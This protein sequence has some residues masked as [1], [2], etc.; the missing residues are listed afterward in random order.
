MD[1]NDPE[2]DRAWSEKYLRNR[3][4]A[5][6]KVKLCGGDVYVPDA[7]FIGGTI[8]MTNGWHRIGNTR[9][10]KHLVGKNNIYYINGKVY[11]DQ[12]NQLVPIIIRGGI[13]KQ[14]G[15]DVCISKLKKKLKMA[16]DALKIHFQAR[17][18]HVKEFMQAHLNAPKKKPW[19]VPSLAHNWF[20]DAPE[21]RYYHVDDPNW[22]TN[23]ERNEY[24]DRVARWNA[25]RFGRRGTPA[26]KTQVIAS[27]TQ[28]YESQ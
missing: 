19:Q 17:G 8:Q 21:N 14:Y 13:P 16:R 23:I 6:S 22:L 1:W 10:V 3:I 5:A 25:R 11:L 18:S 24:W 26:S 15:W 2:A 4:R 20:W 7:R 27:A 12:G 28:P 9:E